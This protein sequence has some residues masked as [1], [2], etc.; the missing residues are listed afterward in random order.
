MV[1]KPTHYDQRYKPHQPPPPPPPPPQQN[2]IADF[3]EGNQQLQ[4]REVES[5]LRKTR[6]TFLLLQVYWYWVEFSR[7]RLQMNLL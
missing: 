4:L 3:L 5:N 1:V 7:W 6:N 2:V